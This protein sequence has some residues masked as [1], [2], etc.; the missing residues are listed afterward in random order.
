MGNYGYVISN[1]HHYSEHWSKKKVAISSTRTKDFI[2][3]GR[4]WNNIISA[5]WQRLTDMLG[6][7]WEWRNIHN[8]SLLQG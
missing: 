4:W 2:H 3:E 6:G 7:A 1:F 5:V 8:K